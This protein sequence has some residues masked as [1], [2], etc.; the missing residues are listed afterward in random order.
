M[1]S[2][3]RQGAARREDGGRLGLAVSYFLLGRSSELWACAKQA[4]PPR[5]LSDAELSYFLS[6]RSAGYAREQ[7]DRHSSAGKIIGVEEHPNESRV[8]HHTNAVRERQE[9]RGGVDGSLRGLAGA[10][11]LTPPATGGGRR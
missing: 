11:Q 1:L 5:A 6:R 10:D 7:I 8:R 9:D 4:G 2:Q 3:G